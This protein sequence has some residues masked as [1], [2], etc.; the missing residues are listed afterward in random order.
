MNFKLQRVRASH[1]PAVQALK[2]FQGLIRTMLHSG[3]LSGGPYYAPR[4]SPSELDGSGDLSS[5]TSDPKNYILSHLVKPSNTMREEP[6]V[7]GFMARQNTHITIYFILFYF[8][9]K[10]WT[11]SQ[12]KKNGTGSHGTYYVV[13]TSGK[14]RPTAFRIHS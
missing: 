7:H 11:S 1:F 13:S 9:R 6:L 14:C 5:Q 4:S 8:A 12:R 3:T 10:I 2:N